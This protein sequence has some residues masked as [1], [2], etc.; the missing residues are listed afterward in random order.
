LPAAISS[1][2]TPRLS[3]FTVAQYDRM[4][5]TGTI[6]ESENV[7]LIDGL[8]VTKTSRNRPHVQA[9]KLGL[10]ALW[11]RPEPDLALVRGGIVDYATRDVTSGDVGLVVEIAASSLAVGDLLPAIESINKG[12]DR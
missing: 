6:G 11:S 12:E 3:R 2:L 9:G 10:A 4:V 7:E 5:E 1:H 8:L